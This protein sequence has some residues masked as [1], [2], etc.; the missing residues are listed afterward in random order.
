MSK[1]KILYLVQLPPPVH[2]ASLMNKYLLESSKVRENFELD[3]VNLDF[4]SEIA[5]I[6]KVDLKKIIKMFKIALLILTNLLKN[7]YSLIYLTLSPVGGAMYRD[8][9][10]IFL[11]KIFRVKIVYHLHGKG[12]KKASKN[13]INFYIY[14]FIFKNSFVITLAE[15]LKYDIEEVFFGKAF[16]VPNG[17]PKNDLLEKTAPIENREIIYLSNLVK[18]KGVLVMLDALNLLNKQ[19]IN[20]K[21][22]IIGN[23]S[24]EISVEDLKKR[25]KELKLEKKVS[26]LGPKYGKEKFEELSKSSIFCFPTYFKNECFPL[27]LLEAMMMG[28]VPV[29]SDNGAISTI[30]NHGV[31][32]YIVPMKNSKKLSL[33]LLELLKLP[34]QNFQELSKKAKEKYNNE[35]TIQVFENRIIDVFETIIKT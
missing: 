20:F 4:N 31:N 24:F 29:A 12:I 13:I 19:N 30:I 11:M 18:S 10:F 1:P 21:A 26:V 17:I 35:Y 22:K 28:V 32:G 16:V 6:G 33:S 14:K 25:V 8:S 7:K 3:L 9:L 23:S 27:S 15:N 34:D 2:G 5:E